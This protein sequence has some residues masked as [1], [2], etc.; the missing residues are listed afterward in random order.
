LFS[1]RPLKRDKGLK[2]AKEAKKA[3]KAK[4]A[5]KDRAKISWELAPFLVAKIR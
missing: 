5:K 2:R 3:K 1:K 4:A